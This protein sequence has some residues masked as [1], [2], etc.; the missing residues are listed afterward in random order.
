MA[1]LLANKA[2]TYRAVAIGCRHSARS[3]ATQSKHVE[4]NSIAIDGGAETPVVFIHGLYGS[5]SN[6]RS[7]MKGCST[8][9]KADRKF[10]SMDLRNHGSSGH[11]SDM[12][13]DAMAEDVK[14]L[15]DENGI[16]SAVI[17]GHSLGGRA[18]MA[19]ALLYPER[20][21]RLMVVDMAP[22]NLDKASESSFG[23]ATKVGKALAELP[24]DQIT[25]RAHAD[26][27]LAASIDDPSI[28]GFTLQ[29]LLTAKN[30]TPKWKW[31]LNLDVL[32]ESR[33]TMAKFELNGVPAPYMGQTNFLR[34]TRSNY[35]DPERH[36]PVIRALFPFA[37]ISELDAGHWVHA[38]KSNDFIKSVV[39]FVKL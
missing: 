21:E 18:A 2:A 29:N 5:C 15:L 20:V 16:E 11:S 19:S 8:K 22:S 33:D 35:V 39:K 37:T 13:Y 6:F 31:R 1:L 38:E 3:L 32:N 10:I 4:I 17:V 26:E 30:E 9:L 14:H 34:G 36:G 7:I 24:L 23:E 12:T 28:R 25:T 27:L